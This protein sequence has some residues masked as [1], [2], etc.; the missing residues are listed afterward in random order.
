MTSDTDMLSRSARCNRRAPRS[1]SRR[2]DA[3]VEGLTVL[4]AVGP[5]EVLSRLPGASVTTVGL[6]AGA[7]RN[8]RGSL[9]IMAD[10]TI[11]EVDE[12][13]VLVVPG[14][15]ATR[16]LVNDSRL[17]SWL[18]RVHETTEWTASV[19][20]GSLLLGAAEILERRDATTHWL[21]LERLRDFGARPSDERVV[22][23]GKV[24]TAGGVSAGID[25]GLTLAALIAGNDIA[26]AIQLSIEYDPRPPFDA[27]N[28]RTAPPEIRCSRTKARGPPG[29]RCRA[30]RLASI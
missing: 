10:A 18:G 25:M 22:V 6:D 30:G 4:D 26:Q 1:G 12:T 13:D 21:Q 7:V 19:C 20:T 8:E 5:Y 3:T 9:A 28:A 23:Q 2:T 16:D 27:G 15:I 14:G 11:A 29:T 17:V 24:L